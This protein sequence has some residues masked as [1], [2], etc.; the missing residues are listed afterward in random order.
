[1]AVSFTALSLP[2]LLVKATCLYQPSVYNGTGAE[3]RLNM[4]LD[5]ADDIR[6]KISKI[7][8]DLQLGPNSCSVLKGNSLKTKIDIE[9]LNVYNEDHQL[10]KIQLGQFA[11]AQVEVRLELRGTWKTASSCGL[12]IRATDVRFCSEGRPSPFSRD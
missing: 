2:T 5:I 9:K 7:E 3:T 10:I 1:M 11:T 8:T 4:V 6:D 12:S